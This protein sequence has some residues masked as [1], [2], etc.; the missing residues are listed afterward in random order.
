MEASLGW[1]WCVRLHTVCHP[2][3]SHCQM[4]FEDGQ[5]D[6]KNSYHVLALGL[7]EWL[8]GEILDSAW[9][10]ASEEMMEESSYTLP[11][12]VDLL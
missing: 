2:A 11:R 1:I 6:K 4:L 8:L 5:E 9:K 3:A 10:D 12:F 7:Y